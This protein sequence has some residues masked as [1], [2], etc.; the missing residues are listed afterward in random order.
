MSYQREIILSASIFGVLSVTLFAVLN[1]CAPPSS[2][3]HS[4]IADAHEKDY[5]MGVKNP[6]PHQINAMNKVPILNQGGGNFNTCITFAVTGAMNAVMIQKDPTTANNNLISQQCALALELSLSRDPSKNRQSFW[7]GKNT[8]M[9][10]LT[11]DLILN[12]G[13]IRN[14]QCPDAYPSTNATMQP[15][16][17]VKKSEKLPFIKFTAHQLKATPDEIKQAIRAGH[18]AIINFKLDPNDLADKNHIWSCNHKLPNA[19]AC[20]AG[21][22]T[23]HAVI[24]FGYDDEQ[25]LFKVRNSWGG[26]S[27]Y[28]MTYK[29]FQFMGGLGWLEIYLDPS[30]TPASLPGKATSH[31]QSQARDVPLKSAKK[32]QM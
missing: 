15:S 3:S 16:D 6:F 9:A 20:R 26:S 1:S 4:S 5:S 22:Q 21:I 24:I 29:F 14:S 18:F 19:E 27:D 17:Y 23:G 7:D 31:P 32:F 8:D 28:Y 13:I 25:E 30:I 2:P 10:Q 11:E 12:Y